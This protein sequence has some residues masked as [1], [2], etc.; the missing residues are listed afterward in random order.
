MMLTL[1]IIND[2]YTTSIDFVLA[3]P[4]AKTDVDIYME[5]P[6]GCEVEEGDYVCKLINSIAIH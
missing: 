1:A 6:L 5:V 2:L 3:F 4:Q